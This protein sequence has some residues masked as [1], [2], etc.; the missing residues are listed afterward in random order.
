MQVSYYLKRPND[1]KPTAIFA[2]IWYG[3]KECKYYLPDSI[4]PKHWNRK[5][6][7]TRETKDFKE[8]P[9]F[10]ARL[11]RW[12]AE[13]KSVIRKYSNDNDNLLPEP[14]ELKKLLDAIIKPNI[15]KKTDVTLVSFFKDIIKRSEEGTRL[16]PRTGKPISAGTI[17]FYKQSLG[18][19]ETF[20]DHKKRTYRFEDVDMSFYSDYTEYLTKVLKF[21]ANTIGKQVQTV[22]L[23]M[24][25][26]N[27]MQLTTNTLHKGKRFLS[28]SE[29]TDSIYLNENK[30]Q[31]INGVDLSDNP[32]L[33]HVRDLFLI[34][35]YTGLR[36]SD[37]SILK[38]EQ[39]KDGFIEI[40]QQVKTG[41]PVIIP[42]HS[43]VAAIMEK[44]DGA[45]PKSL[46]NQKMND[47]IKEVAKEV[48]HLLETEVSVT[49][50]KA[51]KK[52]TE[53]YIK[54]DLVTTH[55]AR[56]SFATNEYLAG[57]PTLTIMAI[58]GHKTEKAF[59]K[60]IRVTPS[61]HAKHLSEIWAKRAEGKQPT[62]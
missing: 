32:R 46:S 58:T 39:V 20:Q 36:F 52:K 35:C 11:T 37:F 26:A 13:I 1:D 25:E 7:L 27:E 16:H 38:P 41:K 19:L 21:A 3:G 48:D 15:A 62:V 55:T 44:Y 60:Y 12:K 23:I 28:I 10:N 22:K 40:A 5:A 8:Y 6:Q 51:G 4:H 59:L 14:D 24:N 61:E 9:E 33:D 29:E 45:L 17:K 30:L 50:T 34:G 54:A 18:R 56:R 53:R 43:E 57:T 2:H 49:Y 31:L 42:V 47:Y